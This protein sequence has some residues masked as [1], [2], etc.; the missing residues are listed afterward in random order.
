MKEYYRHLNLENNN[1]RFSPTPEKSVLKLLQQIDP[2]K[3]VGLDNL[4]GRFLKDGAS[5]LSHPI[6]QLINLSIATSAF[7]DQCKIAK[8]KPI[9]KKSSA[10]D[11][12]NYRPILLL[13][14]LNII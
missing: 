4:G 1:F 10:L 14:Y 13:T 6:T 3:A 2:S 12:K 8:L 5:E 7:P 9:Y 11:P